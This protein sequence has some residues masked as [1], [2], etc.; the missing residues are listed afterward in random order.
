MRENHAAFNSIQ[1]VPARNASPVRHRQAEG[2][3]GGQREAGGSEV[4]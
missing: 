3:P 1:L 2:M 4:K